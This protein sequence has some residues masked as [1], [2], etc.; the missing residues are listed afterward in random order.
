MRQLEPEYDMSAAD[1]MFKRMREN[2]QSI[3]GEEEEPVGGKS[4]KVPAKQV[5]EHQQLL[6]CLQRYAASARF[7]PMLKEA[8]L[9]LTNL[10]I[11]TVAELKQLQ[12]RVRTVCS[13]SGAA[14]GMLYQGILGGAAVVEKIAP[15]RLMDLDGYAAALRADPE[16]EAVAEM[17]ELDLGYAAAMSP[18][19]R[20]GLC[21]GKNALNVAAMNSKKN[22]L[23]EQL[24]AQQAAMQG[25]QPPQ[26]VAPVPIVAAPVYESDVKY[27]SQSVR[28][29]ATPVYDD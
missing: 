25:Q 1:H 23:I 7:A 2:G 4:A 28:N 8:G 22:K 13:S 24:L 20:M 11:K 26:P 10:E 27:P 12:I 29:G 16:F 5:A 14:S 6:M 15:K 17:L 18:L 21:L 9:K 3:P 19:Q